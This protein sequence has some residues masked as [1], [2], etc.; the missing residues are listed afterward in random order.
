MRHSGVVAKLRICQVHLQSQCEV[1]EIRYSTKVQN[2]WEHDYCF[3]LTFA[4]RYLSRP[5]SICLTTCFVFSLQF[6]AFATVVHHYSCINEHVL[7]MFKI[8]G[9]ITAGGWVNQDGL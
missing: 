8:T 9:I 3:K 5:C 4:Q 7:T 2:Q 6:V 1:L